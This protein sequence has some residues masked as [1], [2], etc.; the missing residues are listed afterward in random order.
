[1]QQA[2]SK[3]IGISSKTSVNKAILA[4]LQGLRAQQP[5]KL[6]E[7]AEE[8]FYLSPES[9][10]V[11]GAWENIPYQVGIMDCISNDDIS[12]IT[13]MKSARTGYTKIIV[14]A[15]GY[16]AEHKH[17]GQVVYQPTDSDAQ[18]FVKDEIDPM[19]RDVPVIRNIF[20][21]Y[22]KK[23]KSNTLNKKVFQGSTLDIL[24]G[25]SP[26]NYRRLT[27]DV[28]IY[29]EMD[30]FD[31]DIGGEGSATSLGDTRLTTSSFPKSIRGS[32]PKI[33]ES[34]QIEASL[35]EADVVLKYH[36]PCPHCNEMQ[37]LKWGGDKADFG[38]KWEKDKPETAHYCC[39]HCKE[40]F[41]YSL[42]ADLL[43]KGEWRSNDGVRLDSDGIF[44]KKNKV[45]DAP[46]HVGFHLW[47]AY[48]I[49]SSW[50]QLA[51]EYLKAV[52][53]SKTG[54][55]GKLKTFVN[56]R[57]GESWEEDQGEKLDPNSLYQ[58]REH[59][60]AELPEG[61]LYLT[62]G[63]DTQDDRFEYSVKGW[64]IGEECWDIDY[65]RLYGDL[66]R[67]D[68]WNVLGEKL[69]KTYT[70]FD[71]LELS[72]ETI[73][74]DSGGHFTDEVYEFSKKQGLSWVVPIKGASQPGKP[75]ATFPRKRNKKGVYLTEVGTDNAKS[76][77][78]QRL[79]ILEPGPGYCH[80]PISD[81][82][83]ETHFEQLTVEKKVLSYS[84][85]K[86]VFVWVLPS[87]RRNE[88]L[89]CAVYALAALRIAVQHK[90]IDLNQLSQLG[91]K[92]MQKNTEKRRKSSYWNK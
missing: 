61:V 47:A 26:R 77:I 73:C 28:V 3:S 11:S 42:L 10:S 29:D 52:I 49:F 45:I 53:D 58:R 24:G 89:D 67:P 31:H 41:D 16:F 92:R 74:H 71:G 68:I 90:G 40:S 91:H 87:G 7:W 39:E 79:N 6:S 85:G 37:H 12:V 32:T 56:T 22:G 2:E 20:P 35:A 80:W 38:I 50:S 70:R 65:V 75:I 34:S 63:I 57:L 66:S 64:G 21:T 27:K 54:N 8:N 18:D 83:D 14:A 44:Y 48:S 9:S 19:T 43:E 1:M 76:I 84:R 60:S 86:R 15:I 69:R 13:W 88:P 82:F 72:I 59:Y 62:A 36:I 30:G 46:Y 33:K 23:S 51:S 78:Y 5:M 81:K 4:G 55:L 17:R 25:T